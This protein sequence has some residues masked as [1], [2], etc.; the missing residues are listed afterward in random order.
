[1]KDDFAALIVSP[2]MAM[3]RSNDSAAGTS[4]P[5]GPSPDTAHPMPSAPRV[6]FLKPLVDAANIEIGE[7]TYY[8]DPAGP[9]H[10]VENCV[11]YHYPFDGDRLVIGRFCA[12]ASGVRFFM[13]GANHRL[14][15]FSTYPFAIF[16]EGWEDPD[17]NWSAGARGDT[18]VGN[19]VWIGN[20]ATV[21]AG[22]TIGDG[23]VI[24][25][26]AMVGSDVAPYT[27]VA[28]NPARPVRQRFDDETIA[29]LLAIAWWNWDAAK[30]T[31]NLGAIRG[32]NIAAL[33]AAT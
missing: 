24:G 2:W 25:A 28:G 31:H 6:G 33:E 18:V 9:E 16:G 17:H 23:A 10:F 22:V 8:D 15:G 1:M 32:G 30:L 27:I 29:R 11:L 12:I 20:G 7:F 19:D 13:S 3:Q 4:L 21:L 14:D 5:A 26:G